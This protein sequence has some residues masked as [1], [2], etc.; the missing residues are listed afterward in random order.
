N[1]NVYSFG[2]PEYGQLGH[3]TDGKYFV[4]S[5]KIEFQCENT[6]R[7]I[8]VFVEKQRDGQ[9]SPVTDVDVREIACGANHVLI[10]D[11]R[12]RVFS[13]GFGGYGRLGHSE[14][15]D[16]LVP[17]LLKFFE[18]PN[19]GALMIAAGSTY[20]LAVSEHGAL[21]FWGQT[22]TSGEANM[23]PKLVQDLCGWKIRSIGTR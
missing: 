12:K 2:C 22:K 18:G 6:P 14:P 17:R 4:K 10:S 5:N 9:V 1:G 15:K 3:N 20:S 19:R 13:W 11:S 8:T 7:V 23:Y 16:E 21:Y